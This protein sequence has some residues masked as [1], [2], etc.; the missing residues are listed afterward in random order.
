MKI[1]FFTRKDFGG[2]R[3]YI[4]FP[5]TLLQGTF[6]HCELEVGD[7]ILNADNVN[8]I[9]Y[10]TSRKFEPSKVIEIEHDQE[11][12]LE[13]SKELLGKQYSWGAFF[14]LLL[15]KWGIDPKGLI[16]SELVAHMLSKCAKEDKYRIPFIAV[17]PYRWTPN[18]VYQALENMKKP[19]T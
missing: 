9:Q 3:K 18:A 16:C 1:R 11:V 15:P 19:L 2:W 6:V 12:Y 4:W 17:P 7:V 14:R 13:E 10:K 5:V 8:G